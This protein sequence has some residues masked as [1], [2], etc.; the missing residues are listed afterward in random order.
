[1]SH[2]IALQVEYCSI[3][4]RTCRYA[5]NDT[6]KIAAKDGISVQDCLSE[7]QVVSFVSLI[8][9]KACITHLA[10]R[11]TSAYND[12]TLWRIKHLMNVLS[13]HGSIRK[14]QAP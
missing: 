13:V 11:V 5:R 1:M 2:N 9:R 12:L 6:V 4:R 14:I 8:Y 3:V 10:G 7:F